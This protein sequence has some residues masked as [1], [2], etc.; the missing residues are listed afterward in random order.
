MLQGKGN[1]L[2]IPKGTSHE[3]F[4]AFETKHHNFQF[5]FENFNRWAFVKQRFAL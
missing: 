4:L 5:N 3:A 1:K 2:A